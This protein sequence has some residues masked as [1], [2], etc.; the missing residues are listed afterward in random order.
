[1]AFAKPTDK[2]FRRF[3]KLLSQLN[4][5]L[6]V[7][8]LS[9]TSK[10]NRRLQRRPWVFLCPEGFD[11]FL[12]QEIFGNRLNNFITSSVRSDARWSAKNRLSGFHVRLLK[13][14]ENVYVFFF[15]ETNSIIRLTQNV[16]FLYLFMI[17]LQAFNIN[18]SYAR[19]NAVV[20]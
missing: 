5:T 15:F 11:S 17:H 13:L 6:F 16:G 3:L 7:H 9:L 10:L 18:I 12:D 8:F 2:Y 1:M 20:V 19:R 14:N 4:R